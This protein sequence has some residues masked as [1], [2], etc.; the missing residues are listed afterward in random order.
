[1]SGVEIAYVQR[2]NSFAFE[3]ELVLEKKKKLK[4]RMKK[5]EALSA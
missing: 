4:K 5:R 2:K 1:V 3:V